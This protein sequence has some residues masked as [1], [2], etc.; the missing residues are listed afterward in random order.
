MFN[1]RVLNSDEVIAKL[2]PYLPQYLE[3][4]GIDPSKPFKCIS[5]KHDDKTPSCSIVP[6][7][8]VS[9]V[10][11][12]KCFGGG[13]GHTGNIFTAA[14]DLENKPRSGPNWVE[15]TLIYLADKYK[16]PVEF[17]ELTESEKFEY[18]TYR[19]YRDAAE[20]IADRKLGDYKH[21]DIEARRRNWDRDILEK[22]G[23]GTI[24]YSTFRES[25]KNMGWNTKF[26]QEIDLDRKD[27]FSEFSM[28]FT[29]KD[30]HGRPVGFAARNLN[31]EKMKTAEKRAPKYINTACNS[32][33]FNIYDKEA[34]LY[35]IHLAKGST[36]PLYLFE[37]YGDVISAYHNGIQNAVAIC[38]STL[39]DSQLALIKSIGCNEII[40]GLDGDAPGQAAVEKLLDEKLSG[41]RDLNIKI[42]HLPGG[43][44]PDEFLRNNTVEEF[45]ALSRM[46]AFEWR[47]R[48]FEEGTPSDEICKRMIPLIV[49]EESYINQE[50]M[51]E[52]LSRETN[53]SLKFIVAE[54]E[55]LQNL[56]SKELYEHR[57]AIVE[58]TFYDIKRNPDDVRSILLQA[59]DQ[60]SEIEN[61]FDEN[62]LSINTT[63]SVLEAQKAD[64]EKKS[65]E[66]AGYYLGDALR[67]LQDKLNGDWRKD[68]VVFLGGKENC[69]KTS[70]MCQIAYEI[71]RDP[72]NNATVI[73][74]ST[75]DTIAQIWPRFICTSQDTLLDL[76][77]VTHPRYWRKKVGPSVEGRRK[78]GYQEITD[79]VREGRLVL[80]DVTYGDTVSY[81]ESLVK[82][83]KSNFPDRN[84]VYIM[85][86]FHK[87]SDFPNLDTRERFTN[88]SNKVKR[89]ATVHHVTVLATA[90][91]TKLGPGMKPSNNNIAEARAMQYDGNVLLHLYNDLHDMGSQ[92]T[93]YHLDEDGETH[94][95]I[96]EI[97][98]GKN[99][100][101]SFKSNMMLKF[102]PKSARFHFI[103][104]EEVHN[105]VLQSKA[106]HIL[107]KEQAK[108]RV[109]HMLEAVRPNGQTRTAGS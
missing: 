63:L 94:L 5:A 92:S 51:C 90:E 72:R 75:D 2:F 6:E 67:G 82:Y 48:R 42:M 4:H 12:Y 83:Y 96:I 46:S 3:E 10:W 9:G 99:K 98:F 45:R 81:G 37:G 11:V 25:L 89:L 60:V 76:G 78:N 32:M 1:D 44:D 26:L 38:S 88:L 61:R 29:V 59:A 91:Y 102:F 57:E 73:Y 105:K 47:L 15:E 77:Q 70:L 20:L 31:F 52:Q 74:H 17:R 27:L 108:E 43:Q 97:I 87:F 33:R 14:S 39:T 21:F 40:L 93:V 103:E 104:K 71:A 36:P 54:L 35:N 85:D 79:L 8:K 28:I 22:L 65:D 106:Q 95:P 50:T 41:R 64:E 24:D 100:V 66:F 56:K 18:N 109:Q 13:C 34:R 58:K 55:R 80:R 7:S 101:S 69:G 49:N 53:R 19:C 30:E 68:C 16:V 107:E 23:V 62:S 84:I 86:N